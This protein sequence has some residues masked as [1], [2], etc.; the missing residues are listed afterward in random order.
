LPPDEKR[1]VNPVEDGR[2]KNYRV[3]GGTQCAYH[4]NAPQVQ[5]AVQRRNAENMARQ[6]AL[7]RL[8]K[9]G[10][11]VVAGP[12]AVIEMLEDRMGFQYGLAKA[13]DL[14]VRKLVEAD[15]LRYEHQAGEQIRGEVQAWVQVNQ[16]V[17]KLGTDYLKIGLDER[18]VR[19]AE[20]HGRLIMQVIQAVMDRLELTGD[21]RKIAA[22]AI[23]EELNRVVVAGEVEK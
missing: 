4:G 2:C 16:M 6:R 11:P 23:P 14:L 20:A 3:P 12:E 7:K 9:D 22:V 10:Y 17:T 19:L 8:E 13:L 1:C 15:E 5:S 21:Q 18:K